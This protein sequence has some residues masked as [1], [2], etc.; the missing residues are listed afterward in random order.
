MTTELVSVLLPLPFDRSFTYAVKAG[1][2]PLPGRFVRV[3]FGPRRAIGVVWDH[4][5][6]RDMAADR[7]KAVE[8]I[9]D[10]PPLSA[11]LRRLADDMAASTL[12]PLGS[13]LR[14]LMPVPAALEPGPV[15]TAYELAPDLDRER[16]D[17]R[18][19]RVAAIVDGHGPLQATA[20]AREAGVSAGIVRKMAE[21]GQLRAIEID[22]D[23]LDLP[24]CHEGTAFDLT[25][26]QRAAADRLVAALDR[27]DDDFWL[28]EGVPGSG[29]TEVYLEAIEASLRAGRPVLVLLPEIALS[30]QWLRRFEARF[31]TALLAWHSGLTQVQ[32]RRTWK[33]VARGDAKVLVGAR[34]ALFLPFP[35][36][37]LVVMDE[38]HDTSFK[39]ED[40]VVYDARLI[41]RRRCAFEGATL[42]LVSATPSLETLIG[43]RPER[44]IVLEDRFASAPKPQV[45]I[46]DLRRQRPPAGT[47]LGEALRD[48]VREAMAAG[49]QAMLFLNRRGYA[50]LTICRACGYRMHCPNCTAWLT[51]HRYRPRLQCHHCGYSRPLPDHCPECG[52]LD[53]IA[54]SGPGV[55]RIADELRSF[56]P[57]ARVAVMTSDTIHSSDSATAMIEAILAHQVDVIIGTQLIAKGHHFPDL[58]F[59]GVVDA[60]IGLGGGDLRAGERTFQLLYQLAGRAGRESRPGRVLIQTRDPGH[61]VMRALAGG[62]RDSFIRA[63]LDERREGHMPPF[64]RLAALILSG[65]DHELVAHEGRRL[66]ACAPD[67]DN[68][69]ILGPAPAPLTM[70]RGRYRER[71]LVKATPE[72]DLPA[73]LRGWLSTIQLARNVR[74]RVDIDPQNFL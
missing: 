35:S 64:G 31:G 29:K 9:L 5:V 69:L 28:L 66:A 26:S 43:V 50:P 15:K 23:R 45:G 40:G 53:H 37:G 18:R 68:V 51:S 19:E 24:P 30:A 71:F 4:P 22:A 32:R 70:L 58:T 6:D 13:V 36:L 42:I 25:P 8:A 62:D 27:P 16:L 38:A 17:E 3:P 11:A 44:H 34:S 41:A 54:A 33:A 74:L 48:G 46:V 73:I 59:V 7:I 1:P 55:E 60:D 65:P 57:E 14:L 52:T 2:V 49:E 67:L 61:P 56:A 12:S 63:E 72:T 10:V 39:Q 20:L 21:A 47:F